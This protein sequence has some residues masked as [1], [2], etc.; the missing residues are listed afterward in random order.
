MKKKLLRK[1]NK[2]S[3]AKKKTKLTFFPHKNVE[4]YEIL[5]KFNVSFTQKLTL[6][7]KKLLCFKSNVRKFAIHVWVKIF[8]EVVFS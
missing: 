4:R 1:N 5:K 3:K 6:L 7:R 8:P 2:Q